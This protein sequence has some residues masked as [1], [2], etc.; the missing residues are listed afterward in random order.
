MIEVR[1]FLAA[2]AVQVLAMSVLF[3]G[4][5]LMSISAAPGQ[6]EDAESEP[7]TSPHR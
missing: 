7:A 1:G 3:P 4:F 6:P 2:F 5:F